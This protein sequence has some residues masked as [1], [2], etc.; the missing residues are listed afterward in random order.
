MHKLEQRPGC[1]HGQM[2]VKADMEIV[3]WVCMHGN[4]EVTHISLR[5]NL[6]FF[7]FDILN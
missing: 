6:P 1:R 4:M 7:S 3:Q 5:E 2:L